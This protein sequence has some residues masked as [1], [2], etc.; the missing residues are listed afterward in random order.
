M[1]TEALGLTCRS[2]IKLVVD[3]GVVAPGLPYTLRCKNRLSPISC[4][5]RVA[6]N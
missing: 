4:S 5:E 3:P 2:L 1:I 6:E